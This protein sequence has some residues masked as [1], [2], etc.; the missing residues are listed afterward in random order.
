MRDSVTKQLLIELAKRRP[1]VAEADRDI[2]VETAALIRSIYYPKQAAF[3]T[4]KVR[5]RATKKTRRAGATTG[6]CRELIARAITV[7]GFRA[8]YVASTRKEAR[9]RAWL[10]DN[11]SGL[12]DVLRLYG[13]PADRQAIEVQIV[14]GVRAD[15][16]D[17]AMTIDFSNGS[18]LDLFGADDERAMRKQRGLSK[19]V[20]WIDEA[21]DFRFLDRFYDAVIIGSLTDYNGECWLTGTP[22]RDC[23]GMFYEITKDDD[24]EPVP[25]KLKRWEVHTIAVVDNPYFGKVIGGSTKK[26][27]LKYFVE[28]NTEEKHGP[29]DSFFEAESAANQIRW[30]RTAGN[31]LLV[32]G[33]KGDEPDFIREWLG[34]WCKEDARYVYPVH[35]CKPYDLL[36]APERRKKNPF[37]GTHPRFADHAPWF[38]LEKALTDLP[39]SLKA[40]K[41]RQWMFAIGA[42]FGYHPDPFALVVWAFSHETQDVYE[43]LSW[44]QTKVHTDDQAAYMKLIWDELNNIV[45]FVGDPAGKQDDFEVWRTRMGLPIEEANK[46]GKNTLEEFLADDIRRGRIHLRHDSA[47]YQEMKHLVY[48]PT[49][50]GKTR[51]VAKHRRAPDGSI[52]GDHACFVAG[53]LI[54][55]EHGLQAI[56][57]VDVGTKVNTRS[58]YKTVTRAWKT[59]RRELFNVTLD[60]GRE[61]IGTA[62]HPFW[63]IK[64]FDEEPDD[65]PVQEFGWCPLAHLL[66]GDLLAGSCRISVVARVEELFQEAD[67][68]NLT[69]ED[70]HEYFAN[71]VL[72]SNCD[73]ARYAYADLTHYMSRVP[74]A[75]PKAGSLEAMNAEEERIEKNLDEEEQRRAERLAEGDEEAELNRVYDY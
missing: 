18:R 74:E 52:P 32:K 58:G 25:D 47:L 60:D 75:A 59:G 26:G 54:E 13:T 67:V 21:Q 45:V 39:K 61:I 9:E 68:Y 6:G 14:G 55:I 38:N 27:E 4:S 24:T 28:D 70:A 2:A 10:S 12:V 30:D 62:D 56:E 3:Y 71:G 66:P 34:R 8:T 46:K 16:R 11:K 40:N 19:H 53:T 50:V 65:G 29:Y 69:V 41:R 63:I 35:T 5:F 23:L 15:I 7:P 49:K 1:V 73:C 42:D 20:Y 43:L 57:H 64:G 37:I 48:L 17:Q 72:V 36:Y 22:G 31:A 33:W 44:K 51:E